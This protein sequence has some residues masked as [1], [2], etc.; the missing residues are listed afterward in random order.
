MAADD[1]DRRC[2]IVTIVRHVPLPELETLREINSDDILIQGELSL[3]TGD[4]KNGVEKPYDGITPIAGSGV[5]SAIDPFKE[6]LQ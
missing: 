6:H 3:T 4:E 2:H 1:A 5:E